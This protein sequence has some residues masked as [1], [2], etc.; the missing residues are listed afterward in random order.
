MAL[1]HAELLIPC[2]ASN[3]TLMQFAVHQKN[4][5]TGPHT[6]MAVTRVRV[7]GLVHG[8]VEDACRPTL[9]PAGAAPTQQTGR[10]NSFLHVC[11]QTHMHTCWAQAQASGILSWRETL[12]PLG[13]IPRL[14]P[15]HQAHMPGNTAGVTTLDVGHLSCWYVASVRRTV[16]PCP[17]HHKHIDEPL[18]LPSSDTCTLTPVLRTPQQPLS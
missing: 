4:H 15:A 6:R 18:Y 17:T 12:S 7:D 1:G 3:T 8:K 16:W 2:L 14:R 10:A 13:N 5:T 9:R 11:K